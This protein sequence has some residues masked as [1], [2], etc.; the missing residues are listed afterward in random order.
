MRPGDRVL[1]VGRGTGLDFVLLIDAVGRE[2][3]LF[4]AASLTYSL[5]TIQG[6]RVAYARTGARVWPGE[7][8]A[9][10][11]MALPVGRWRMS[12]PST[13]LPGIT[14]G[15]NIIRAPWTLLVPTTVPTTHRVVRGGHIHIVAG[16]RT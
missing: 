9:V 5:S 10:V 15:A 2:G 13:R 4:D 16:A 3:A 8:I 12:S 1:D 7:R 14:G 11:D 6:W